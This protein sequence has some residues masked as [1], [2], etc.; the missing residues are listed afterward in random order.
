ME[1]KRLGI[2]VQD[3]LA[4]DAFKGVEVMAGSGGLGRKIYHVNVMEVPDILDWVREG[5][6]LLTTLYSL[7][8]NPRAQIDLVPQLAAKNIAALAIKTKRYIDN[9]PDE[10][11]RIAD[12]LDFPILKL[13]GHVAFSSIMEPLLNEIFKF[14]TELLHK[15]E[16]AHNKL[17]DIVLRGGGLD[18]LVQVLGILINGEVAIVNRELEPLTWMTKLVAEQIDKMEWHVLRGA[19]RLVRIEGDPHAI[20]VPLLAGGSLLGFI[21]ACLHRAEEETGSHSVLKEITL[22]RAATVAS[23]DISYAQTVNEVQRRFRNEFVIDLVEGAFPSDTVAHQRAKTN[24]WVLHEKMRVLLI[25]LLNFRVQ[26]QKDQVLKYLR[27]NLGN[28]F[29]TGEMGRDIILVAP[30]QEVFDIFQ[31][32]NDHLAGMERL[33][34]SKFLIG[35]GREVGSIRE[36]KYSYRQARRAVNTAM[37]VPSL[38]AIVHYDQLGIYRLLEEISGK[39]EMHAYVKDHLQVLIDYDCKN[40]TNLMETLQMYFAEGGQLKQVAEKMFLHYNTVKYRIERIE[41]LLGISFDDPHQ[42]LSLEVAVKALNFKKS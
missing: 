31:W 16:W 41:Q 40:N 14:Q 2:S 29:V 17:I 34:G 35:V 5:E 8:N 42:R 24:N 27:E 13:P 22:E 21:V 20:V 18:E 15:A 28:D 26:E 23:L 37:E 25:R 6:L 33:V 32:L 19:T 30:A 1:E 11:L 7:R 36:V 3:A 10:A 12:E 39:Q 9:L 4:L 38:G